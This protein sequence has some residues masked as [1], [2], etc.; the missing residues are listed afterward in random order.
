M[1]LGKG[2]VTSTGKPTNRGVTCSFELSNTGTYSA[3]GQ[4]HPED[5]TAYLKSD[6]YRLSAEVAGRGWRTWLPN[7]LAT[8]QFGK[9]TT[10]RVSVG[11]TAAAADT[12]FVKLTAT[13]ESDPTKTVT[14][15]CRVE[16]S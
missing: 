10:V 6:V 13:S 3:G 11:A 14:K 9:S 1:A 16:K 12:G 15:Q 2:E 8:A 5:A 4:Q 7:P